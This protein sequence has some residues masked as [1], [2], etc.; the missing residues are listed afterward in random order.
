MPQI[1]LSNYYIKNIVKLA[2]NE[3]LY[4]SG[5]ITSSLVKNKKLIKVKL[6][7]NQHAVVA[8]LEFAKQTFKLID[9]KIKFIIKKKEG[10]LVKKNEIIATVEGR[11]ENILIG[12]RVALNFMGHIS[13]I[14][15][16]TNQ[17]VKLVNKKSKICCTRKTIPTLRVIQKYA[18][19]L[20]GGTNH[21]FN[22]SDEFLIKDNHI[23]SSDIKTLVSLAIKNKK[24]KKIT[25][26]VDNLNQLKQIIGL[27]FD[28]VLF[29][30][31]NNKTLKVGVKMAKKYYETEA[32]GNVTLKSVKK[33]AATGVDR[34][35]I[36]SITHSVPAIDF[37][38]EF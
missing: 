26:E 28:T 31:M 35:S 16:K 27:K 10:S 17:F 24:G 34:I 20:G 22:L 8:G 37:K 30:N 18:V 2:L 21:R 1:K 12:E 14:A 13:G 3:D 6:I 4:P 36:G 38:L 11:A 29:D 15:T 5:D 9:S 25:V 19:K 33:I 32:S 7:S 23:A